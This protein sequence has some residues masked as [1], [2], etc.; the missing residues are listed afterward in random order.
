SDIAVEDE[1][2]SQVVALDEEEADAGAATVSAKR[3]P[4][5]KAAA[6]D[7]EEDV[8]F[9]ELEGEGAAVEEEEVEEEEERVVVQEK[10]VKAAPWGIMP[11]I[12]M[13]P[14]VVVMVLVGIMGFEM[15]QSITGYK[16][17]G[18]LTRTVGEMIGQKIKLVRPNHRDT[19]PQRRRPS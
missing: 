3:K 19:E 4:K 12:V 9:G 6:A 16:P 1:S 15:I 18:P 14:C 10:V 5:K 8:D 11:T 13:V 17:V 7:I 2:G